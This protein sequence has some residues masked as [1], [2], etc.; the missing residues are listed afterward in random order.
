LKFGG[1]LDV[2]EK[3]LA[4]Q[5]YFT[6]FRAKVVKDINFQVDFVAGNSKKLRNLGSEEKIS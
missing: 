4:S 6:I 5:I 1:I 3:P 2:V